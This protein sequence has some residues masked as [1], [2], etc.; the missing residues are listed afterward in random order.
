MLQKVADGPQ[1]IVW[2]VPKDHVG[3]PRDFDE[4]GCR[5]GVQHLLHAVQ[6]WL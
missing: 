6:E 3:R 5:H 4:S 2:I 1:E